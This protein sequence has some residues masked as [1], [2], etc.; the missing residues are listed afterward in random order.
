MKSGNIAMNITIRLASKKT[1]GWV[2]TVVAVQWALGVGTSITIAQTCVAP[3]N[4]SCETASPIVFDQLPLTING[5]LGCTNDLVDRPY[6]DLFYQYDCTVSGDYAIELC[7]SVGDTYLR[8]Y[9]TACSFLSSTDTFEDDDGCGGFPSSDARL[10]IP[11]TAGTSY[12]IE[13]GAWREAAAFPPNANDDF[14]LK[15]A[16]ACGPT[17][18]SVSGDQ[19]ACVGDEVVLSVDSPGVSTNGYQW[20]KDGVDIPFATLPTYTIPSATAGDSGAYSVFVSNSCGAVTVQ[21]G[22]LSVTSVPEI[23]DQPIG[24][25]LCV[26]DALNLE[27]QAS[28]VGTLSYQWIKDGSPLIGQNTADLAIGTVELAD[29]GSYTVEVTDDCGNVTSDS[30]TVIVAA[31]APSGLRYAYT[32]I[33]ITGDPVPDRPGDVFDVFATSDPTLNNRSEVA[34]KA[35]F[36][37]PASGNE[38]IYKFSN[39]QLARLVD[40]SFD[41]NPPGQSGATSWT[42][43]GPTSLNNKGEVAFRGGFSFGDNSQG[44]YL[45]DMTQTL[46]MFDD[47]PLQPV[48]EQPTAIG[49]TVFPFLAGVL[50]LVNDNSQCTTIASFFDAGFVEHEGLYFA[51]AGAPLERIVDE[52]ISPP[53]QPPTARYELNDPFMSLNNLGDV[54]FRAGVENG[55]V[56]NGLYRYVRDEEDVFV[57][58]DATKIPPGQPETAR[59]DVTQAFSNMNDS[60]VVGFRSTYAGGVGSEGIYLGDGDSVNQ[61]IVDN[62]GTFPVPGQPGSNFVDFGGPVISANGTVFFSARFGTLVQQQQGLYA[63]SNGVIT[64]IFDFFD[65]VPGQPDGTFFAMGSYVAN[66]HDHV[67]VAARFGGGQGDEGIYIHD[68]T[69]LSRVIDEADK[70]DGI[71]FDNLHMVLGVGGSG[72]ED[73]KP[74]TLNDADQV[75]FRANLVGGGEGIF[76]ATPL[77]QSDNLIETTIVGGPGNLADSTG[78]GSVNRAFRMGTF[79]ITNDQYV[80]FLNAVAAD[81]VNA[82]YESVMTTSLRGGILR[83]GAPGSY[84]YSVKPKF[85]DKPANGFRWVSAARFCN[86]LHNGKPS[87]PQDTSTTESGAYDMSGDPGAIVRNAQARWFLPS[88]DEWHKAAYFDPFNGGADAGGTTDY[89]EYP[90]RSDFTPSLATTDECGVVDNPGPNVAVM[91]KGADWNGTCENNQPP[92]G[93]LATVGTAG[94]ISP[95]GSFDMAGNVFEWTDTIGAPAAGNPTRQARGGDFSN[96]AVLARNSFD[97]D[98][99]QDS[100]A[101][102][103]GMRVASV[104]GDV[105][106][107]ADFDFDADRDLVDSAA[108]Q[109]CFSGAAVFT[110]E[111]GCEV[112]DL[113]GDRDVDTDDW[114]AFEAVFNG[115]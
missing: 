84:T 47:N 89:W 27:I 10:V 102:N 108:F 48:P 51:S 101:A 82:L 79:E 50:P 53:N 18:S 80:E 107:T 71:Q 77:F 86:W 17:I 87:G 4:E 44:M 35:N 81:D 8:V 83:N 62:S 15:V 114:S 37:G 98:F 104:L 85:G 1:I 75:A 11:L 100:G 88:A 66:V 36:T 96:G 59:F 29:A 45:H 112:F 72:G 6:F 55:T 67:V 14:I 49:F 63:S 68:G 2:A 3:A 93:N 16:M 23:T 52:L 28:G 46:L 58:A 32:K 30:A 13:I 56:T 57:V 109:R 113:D 61:L 54:A 42:S 34:F 90:T 38:G 7:G 40:D 5:V 94:P 65:P 25:S 19:A 39:G 33:A 99:T 41:F 105:T 60:G 64:K 9:E 73:G 69:H 97:L 76:L 20:K 115:P 78:Y 103:F 24:Q 26:G 70:V 110:C 74:R 95:W 31:C 12:W 106:G 43:F 22:A 92:C 21:V 111:V 91:E